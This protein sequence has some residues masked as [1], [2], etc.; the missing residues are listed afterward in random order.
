[1]VFYY[2][3]RFTDELTDAHSQNCASKAG[4]LIMS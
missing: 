3:S 2:L 1:M 4:C